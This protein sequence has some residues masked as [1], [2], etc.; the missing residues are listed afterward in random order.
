MAFSQV[1]GSGIESFVVCSITAIAQRILVFWA[2]LRQPMVFC[3]EWLSEGL[4]DAQ[5]VECYLS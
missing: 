3:S 4:G 5:S 1:N 2:F